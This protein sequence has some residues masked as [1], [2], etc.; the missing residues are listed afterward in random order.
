MNSIRTGTV[1]G[2]LL[3]AFSWANAAP[4]LTV[5]AEGATAA[6]NARASFLA[7]L[8]AGHLTE[9]FED[10]TRF[11]VGSQSITINSAAGVGSFTSVLA[12]SG[13]RCDSS[14][15][16]C[17]K[18]LA[19]LNHGATPFGGRF[20]TSPENWL[21]SMDARILNIAPTAGYNALG[22]YMTDPNDAGGRFSIE[23][24]GYMFGD[25]F[26]SALGNGKVFYLS[27]FDAQGL[28]DISIFSNNRNDGFGL[29]DV[30]V[31]VIAVPEPGTLALFALGL[32]GLALSRSRKKS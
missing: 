20:S 25:I 17:N 28:G 31:G 23:V 22:F 15:F 5:S 32:L 12:G 16:N 13:G 10:N 1:I 4:L 6:G 30:T 9:G 11:S 29:D 24:D 7:S 2:L 27:L 19:V 14:G 18:G 21:D 8:Q 26:G 3:G